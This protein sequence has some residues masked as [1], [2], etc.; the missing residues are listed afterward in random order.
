VNLFDL[1]DPARGLDDTRRRLAGVAVGIVTNNED[2]EGMGRVKVRFP[3]LSDEDESQWARI[4]V[5][6]AGDGR[7]VYFLPEV[8]DEVL[9][10]FGHGDPR[11]PYVVGA[12][13]NGQDAPPEDNADGKNDVRVIR[14]RS[15][16][17]LRF[18][19]SDAGPRV[20]IVDSG[21]NKI[22]VDTAADVITISAGKD[23]S[24][25]AGSGKVR[26]EATKL[27]IDAS[28]DVKIKSGGQ[29]QIE[30]GATL[31]LKGALVNIN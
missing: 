17:Q 21:G 4:A 25:R 6:M 11:L 18:D 15:G 16:H 5:P 1:L 13:W 26:L 2:P 10:A 9:V 12:L 24:I 3:W 28:A 30:A 29:M 7:G 8:D 31:S 23:V 20:E 27:E 19:D 14:S 22:V